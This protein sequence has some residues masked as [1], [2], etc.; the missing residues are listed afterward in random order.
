M[1]VQRMT[2]AWLSPFTSCVVLNHY[3]QNQLSIFDVVYG[4]FLIPLVLSAFIESRPLKIFQVVILLV[5]GAFIVSMDPP[6][7]AIGFVI[8]FFAPMYAHTYGFMDKHLPAKIAGFVSVYIILFAFSLT[9]ILGAIMW[10][11]MCITIHGAYWLNVQDSIRK[12]RRADEII[13]RNL[14][15]ELGTTEA[16]LKE[17]VSAGMIL[18]DEIKSKEEKHGCE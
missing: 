6:S 14:E 18:V 1:T 15:Q 9:D 10:L 2:G 16:L 4:A 12:N 11:W 13:K 17:T 7:R 5:A 8:M 3:I